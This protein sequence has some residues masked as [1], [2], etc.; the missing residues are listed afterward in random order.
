MPFFKFVLKNG[1]HST[2]YST[3]ATVKILI[4]AGADLNMQ[5]SSG[6]TALML[7][8]QY[9]MCYN[10]KNMED[11]IKL[12]I[13]S[14]TNLELCNDYGHNILKIAINNINDIYKCNIVKM[15]IEKKRN[16]IDAHTFN[17]QIREALIYS[18]SFYSGYYAK[19]DE[20][21]IQLLE[22]EVNKMK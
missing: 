1:Y 11:T 14:N 19:Y 9:K 21:I 17:N 10:K 16:N 13:E 3:Y 18:T 22:N 6:E 2:K 12:L 7:A 20:G 8:I 15:I 4:D 5:I